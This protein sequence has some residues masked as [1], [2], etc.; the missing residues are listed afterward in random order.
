MGQGNLEKF[1]AFQKANVL[2]DLVVED[3][4]RLTG[5]P[6][7]WRLVSQQIASA[8][9]ICANMEEGYGRGSRKDYAHF[10][11]LSRGSARE[12]RG[13]YERMKHWLPAQLIAERV[14]LCDEIIGILSASVEKLRKA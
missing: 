3:M 8:D 11:V 6:E 5:K 7:C 14:A 12:T 9:S 1:G 13:R 2:F 4:N 10:L